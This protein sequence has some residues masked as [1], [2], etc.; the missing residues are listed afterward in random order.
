MIQTDAS[1]FGADN[2]RMLQ[3][4]LKEGPPN[5]YADLDAIHLI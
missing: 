1:P 5:L 2:P 3:P 4:C